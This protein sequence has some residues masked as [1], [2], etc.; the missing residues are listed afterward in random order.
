MAAGFSLRKIKTPLTLGTKFKRKRKKLKLGLVDVELKTKIRSKYLIALEN[1]S[2]LKLPADAYTK[3]FVVRYAKLLGLD[4]KRIVSQY[5]RERSAYKDNNS[6]YMVPRKS[7]KETR[8]V[9]TPRLMI[10]TIT[11]LFVVA[12]FSYIVFQVYGFAAAPE[13]QIAYPGQSEIVEDEL[14]EIRGVTD[15]EAEL[16]VNDQIIQVSSDGKFNTQYKLSKGVNIIEIKAKNRTDKE[17]VE[18]CIVEY[19]PQTAKVD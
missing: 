5:N 12:I 18:T 3:G 14:I 19:K 4:H 10:P 17:N 13:L 16:L 7:V 11:I 1:D 2:W 9:V 8:L 15:T 6:D